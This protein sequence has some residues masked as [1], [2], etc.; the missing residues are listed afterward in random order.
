MRAA[1]PASVCLA[2][3]LISLSAWSQ[4]APV[5]ASPAIVAPTAPKPALAVSNINGSTAIEWRTLSAAQQVALRPLQSS[6]ANLSDQ[7]KR[8]WLSLSATFPRMSANDQSKLHSRMAQWAALSP[9][10]REQARLNYAEVQKISPAQKN[11]KWEAY[12]AL[13]PNDKKKLA[14]AAQPKPPRTALAANPAPSDKIN[15]VPLIESAGRIR[16]PV[17]MADSPGQTLL[18]KPSPPSRPAASRPVNASST[19]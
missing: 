14:A 8:K 17:P 7:Q 5:A 6:W 18:V 16:L 1:Q 19:N 3:A 9:R 10:Q 12:Q 11:E 4:S 15:Q 2:V 13:D